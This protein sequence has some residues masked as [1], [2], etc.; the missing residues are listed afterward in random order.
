VSITTF[1]QAEQ[2]LMQSL[3]GYEQRP[4]QQAL[5][6]FVETTLATKGH[7]FAE[8]GCGVG[9]S[10]GSMIPAILSGKRTV[11]V[12][13]TLA[14]MSQYATKDVPFLA[15]HLGVPFTWALLKGRGN[16]FCEAKAAAPS[17]FVDLDQLAAIRAE[18]DA[19]P[20]H[21]GDLEDLATPIT[22]SEFS[23]LSSTGKEC[24]GKNECPFASACYAEKAKK[25]AA[26]SQ[27][28]ITNTAMLMTDLKVRQMTGGLASM[29]GEFDALIIDEAHELE[30]IATSQL[31]EDFRPG[32]VTKLVKE[33]ENFVAIQNAVAKAGPV[34]LD[35][36]DAVNAS[37]PVAKEGEKKRLGLSF[38]VD[39]ADTYV[40]MIE[41]LRALRDDVMDVTIVRD[42]K[43]AT[44]RRA[45]LIARITVQ[46]YL[47][48]ALITAEDT[49]L[50][51]WVEAEKNHKGNVV[52][53]L[54]T[55]PI[56]VG[57]FL[58]EWLWS[59]GPA[60]LVSAT[61]SVAGDFTFIK[62]RLGLPDA[63]SMSAG[64]PFDYATQALLFVPDPKV[65]DP[66]K[67]SSGWM[68]Y[69]NAATME[70]IDAAKGGALLL[71]TSRTAMRQAYDDLAPRLTSRGFTV[72]AQDIT[73]SNKKALAVEFKEDTHSVLF[74]MKSFFTGVDIPGDSLR[75]VVINKLPF[76]VPNDPIL[77]ARGD[78]VTRNGGSSFNDLAIPSMTL[79][80]TQA[81]GRLIRTA[82]DRGV[83]AILD[84]RLTSTSYG[85]KIVSALPDSQATMSLDDVRAFYVA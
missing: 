14:L 75:L 49:D 60:V 85:K 77:Q 18:L 11:V 78:E 70:L 45:T 10:L 16:Y 32:A 65:P 36:L 68:T 6:A 64:T 37:L 27:V 56:N 71:F 66:K 82:T 5:A 83:V 52:K 38:F 44:A 4:Q 3:P 51:R 69:S 62:S 7:G 55:A 12:T 43:K 29:L 46:A 17:K 80:L 41:A 8:A 84:S 25:H 28:V 79:T 22:R 54:H 76:A 13:A 24:P 35:A 72:L 2:A 1:A 59:Q 48:E 30:D 40:A 58:A 23:E 57:P 81:Y 47:Y 73:S 74:A 19:N 20:S 9:K 50:V 39:R 61:L 21:S 15:E 31:T 26:N 53:I 34:V 63:T 42:D 33:V 67:N